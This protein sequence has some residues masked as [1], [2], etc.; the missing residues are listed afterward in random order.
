MVICA[1]ALAY[2]HPRFTLPLNAPRGSTEMT[3]L[4]GSKTE[5]AEVN[6]TSPTTARGPAA[7]YA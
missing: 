2:G 3:R 4:G 6:T 7:S 1:L 5:L